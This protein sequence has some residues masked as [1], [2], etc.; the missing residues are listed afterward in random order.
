V[1]GAPAGQ[2]LGGAQTEALQ[3]AGNQIGAVGGEL[4]VPTPDRF[5]QVHVIDAVTIGDDD[6]ADLA[7]LLHVA[8]GVDDVLGFEGAI[9]QGVENASAKSAMISAKR[10]RVRSGRTSIN[11]SASMPK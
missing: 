11:W 5:R 1:A 2:P 4:Q 6:L 8:E 3:A 9:G 7:C 10:R